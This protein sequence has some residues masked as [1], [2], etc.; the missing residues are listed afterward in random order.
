[1]R[2]C[3]HCSVVIVLKQVMIGRSDQLDMIEFQYNS[4]TSENTQHSPCETSYGYQ[5]AAHV[6]RMLPIDDAEPEAIDRLTKLA[7]TQVV[8]KELLKLSKD[9]QTARRTSYTPTF[10]VIWYI[11]RP[12]D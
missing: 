1:M 5:P 9:R 12:M 10:K 11:Y 8:V 3:N 4:F 2:Q 7:D 6:D